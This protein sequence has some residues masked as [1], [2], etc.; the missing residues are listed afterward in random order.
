MRR[1]APH[2]W[3]SNLLFDDGLVTMPDTCIWIRF[4]ERADP[5][6]PLGS[7]EEL[8]ADKVVTC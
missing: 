3:G 5:Q 6:G 8:V 2:G 1:G 4:L 7:L